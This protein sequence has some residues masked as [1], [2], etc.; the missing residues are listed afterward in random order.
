MG[1]D[2]KLE[3]PKYVDLSV[4]YSQAVCVALQGHEWMGGYL[5]RIKN[6]YGFKYGDIQVCD[7][8]RFLRRIKY[9]KPVQRFGFRRK[10]I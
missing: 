5:E 8:G 2:Y 4:N 3:L 7:L 1:E 6:S 9:E 10:F